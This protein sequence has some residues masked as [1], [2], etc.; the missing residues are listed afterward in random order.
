MA[1]IK[2]AKKRFIQSEKHRKNNVRN[3]SM[4]KTFIKKV[5]LLILSGNKKNAKVAFFNM[6][7]ILDKQANRGLIHKNKAARYK[8]R[9]WKKINHM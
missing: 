5:N 3:K 9:L 8:S 1:N 6:Q 4:I 7:P 2:S